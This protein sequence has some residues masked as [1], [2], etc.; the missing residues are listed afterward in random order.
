MAEAQAV[1]QNGTARV[2]AA[3]RVL[4]PPESEQVV[5]VVFTEAIPAGA[6]TLKRVGVRGRAQDKDFGGSMTS[7]MMVDGVALSQ[8]GVLIDPGPSANPW[9]VP[10][11][12]VARVEYL[13][14]KG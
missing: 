3:K 13:G 9:L 6:F 11:T 10:W 12:A 4:R 5:L 1:T 2:P 7:A 14:A 8:H